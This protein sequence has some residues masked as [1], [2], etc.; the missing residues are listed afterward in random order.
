MGLRIA[1]RKGVV[2]GEV[3]AGARHDR[4]K[5]ITALLDLGISERRIGELVGVSRGAVQN[6][7][8]RRTGG[9]FPN[10]PPPQD[11]GRFVIHFGLSE[12]IWKSL[13]S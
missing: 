9:A 7:K 3:R 2:S 6:V 8:R 4:D 12:P 11:K 1:K 10:T 5:R 13:G